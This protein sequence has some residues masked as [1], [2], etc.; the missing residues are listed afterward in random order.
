MNK[1]INLLLIGFGP[2]ARRIYYPIITNETDKFNTKIVCAVDLKSQKKVIDEYLSKRNET[3]P[4]YYIKNPHQ[5]KHIH[6]KTQILLNKIVTQYNIKGIILATEPLAHVGY[7][8]WALSKGLNILMDK[9]ISTV[10]NSSISEQAAKQLINDFKFLKTTY[11][12][13]KNKFNPLIF[14][15][16]AQRRYHPAFQKMK[17]LIREVFKETNCPVTS[18]QSFH[19]DGQWRLP[20]EIIDIKYH[21]YNDGYG[22]CS[23]T[24]YH[25]LDIVP[26][27]L[28][29]AESPEKKINNV[30][31]FT[32][33]VRPIDFISQFNLKD[34][35]KVF[36]NFKKVNTYNEKQFREKVNRYGEI[37]AFNSFAFKHDDRIITLANLNFIHNG[38]SQRGWL[39]PKKDLYK[40][41]G[42]I[43][44]E[45]HLI[46]QGPFQAISFISYQSSEINL[47]NKNN[48]YDV[49]NEYHLDIHVFRNH[50]LFPK[51]KNYEKYSI[52]D[53][54]QNIVTGYSRGHQEDARR[55]CIIEFINLVQGK[56]KQSLSNY[57]SHEKGTNLLSAVY[58]SASK[59]FNKQNP[60]VNVMI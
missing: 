47:T 41:N 44:H 57:L 17:D 40:G 9:P 46:E 28:E 59:R 56:T 13:A 60:L 33:F 48:L 43:R 22:K 1:T 52:K 19:S 14:S 55:N 49:G 21:S 29:A 45:S 7:T 3:L 34:Y 31:V 30:D 11:I 18:V 12:K 27:L 16:M 38:F 25:A 5:G 23:H 50:N 15:L 39:E 2:H 10:K 58:L 20:S 53:L 51:W 37:D 6:K 42:R 4:V 24:G 54:N 26:W 32:N 8:Y 36:P 35:E